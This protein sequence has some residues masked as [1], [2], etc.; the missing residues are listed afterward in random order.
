MSD[1]KGVFYFEKIDK[2]KMQ[3]YNNKTGV[4]ANGFYD[5]ERE[6]AIAYDKKLIE[7]GFEPMNVLK[8]K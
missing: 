7:Q 1:Y 4:R 2:W 8:R 6:A 3:Y 5:T